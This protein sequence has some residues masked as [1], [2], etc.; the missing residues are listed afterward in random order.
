MAEMSTA[1]QT[2]KNC[3][4]TDASPGN[5]LVCPHCDATEDFRVSRGVTEYTYDVD[6]NR[7]NGRVVARASNMERDEDRL[8]LTCENCGYNL[9]RNGDERPIV[10]VVDE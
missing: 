4:G 2:C 9:S 10:L 6:L 5:I 8:Q 1:D 7:E 3:A